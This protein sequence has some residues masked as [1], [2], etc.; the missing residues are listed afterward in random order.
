MLQNIKAVVI[1]VP[2]YVAGPRRSHKDYI[3]LRRRGQEKLAWCPRCRMYLSK[4]DVRKLVMNG[5]E[6]CGW[7]NGIVTRSF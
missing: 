2:N 3:S 7:C 4:D 1:D 5:R 6:V